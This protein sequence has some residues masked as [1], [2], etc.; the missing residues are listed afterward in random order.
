[1]GSKTERNKIV[2]IDDYVTDINGTRRH[3]STSE[4]SQR[5]ASE[6]R[7]SGEEKEFIDV[8]GPTLDLFFGSSKPSSSGNEGGDYS[9]PSDSGGSSDSDYEPSSSSS[10]ISDFGKFIFWVSLIGGGI[11]GYNYLN[12]K[13]QNPNVYQPAPVS[14]APA[15][16]IAQPSRVVAVLP[17]PLEHIEDYLTIPQSGTG[18]TATGNVI[19]DSSA[20]AKKGIE[21]KVFRPSTPIIPNTPSSVKN[22]IERK[23]PPAAAIRR[24]GNAFLEQVG[25]IHF[26]GNFGTLAVIDEVKAYYGGGRSYP[27]PKSEY[28]EFY[29][30]LDLNRDGVVTLQEMLAV[31]YVFNNITR[32][33]YEG[34]IPDIVREF[35]NQR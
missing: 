14:A 32:K 25:S 26:Q 5:K 16:E 8:I 19:I 29:A 9:G 28:P 6:A 15:P 20:L 7:H 33:Y 10:G 35:V 4:E 13:K 12:W 30:R 11:L 24:R 17:N 31:Q 23:M 18:N 34:D 3:G 21:G 22:G 27:I 1:M 2:I